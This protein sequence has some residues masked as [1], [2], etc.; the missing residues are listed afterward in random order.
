MQH[1]FT[2]NY[3]YP[4]TDTTPT[5]GNLEVSIQ[6]FDGSTREEALHHQQDAINKERRSNTVD[7]VLDDVNP[8]E[9][10]ITGEDML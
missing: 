10:K 2:L 9:W 3:S 5:C 8:A 1:L 7:H 6:V 4:G